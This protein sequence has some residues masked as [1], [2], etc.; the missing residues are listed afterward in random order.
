M[1][2]I[3]A[4]TFIACFG[5]PVDSIA[6]FQLGWKLGKNFCYLTGF[7]LATTGTSYL[8]FTSQFF[9]RVRYLALVKEKLCAGI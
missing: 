1:N 4:E 3:L 9:F 7:T 5:V 2:M 8:G 6:A